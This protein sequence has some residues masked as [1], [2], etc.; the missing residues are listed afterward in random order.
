M[1]NLVFPSLPGLKWSSFRTPMWSNTVKT[2][3]SGRE[4]A[5]AA[6]SS[7]RWAYRLQYEFLRADSNAELQQLVGFFN[8]HRGNFDTWLFLDVDDSTALDQQIGTGDGV[9]TQFQLLRSYGGFFEPVYEP[10]TTGPGVPAIK[11]GGTLKTAGTDYTIGA[12][13][14]VTFAAAPASSSAI[15]WSG[16]FYWRCRF[17]QSQ[18]ELEQFMRQLWSARSIEFTTRKP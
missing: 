14:V 11:V 17:K 7:P 12:N 15:T 5:R 2:T 6:W 8:K 9:T 1:S 4:F 18:V 3:D 10:F 13:G 16:S